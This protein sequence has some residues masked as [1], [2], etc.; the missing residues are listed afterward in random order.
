[1]K[2]RYLIVCDRFGKKTE[3]VLQYFCKFIGNWEDIETVEMKEHEYA[4]EL[5]G[6]LTKQ[7]DA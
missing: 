3:P 2:L 6:D 5:S 1:M 4:L 7:E